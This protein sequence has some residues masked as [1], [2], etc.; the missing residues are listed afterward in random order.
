MQN[1]QQIAKEK[2][3]RFKESQKQKVKSSGY[4]FK[5]NA[6]ALLKIENRQKLD[7]LCKGP[8]EIKT[9]VSSNA[10][11]QELDKRKHQEVHIKKLKLSG[12]ENAAA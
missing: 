6:L 5:E 1:C 7:Q 9:I 3:I 12:V 4:D 11:I 10:V 2:L 8:C